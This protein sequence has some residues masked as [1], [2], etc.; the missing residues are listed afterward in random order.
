[1]DYRLIADTVIDDLMKVSRYPPNER[2]PKEELESAR[3]DPGGQPR[4]T[5][6]LKSN[7]IENLNFRLRGGVG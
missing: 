5:R 2:L 7:G 3:R 1:M 6:G 4:N